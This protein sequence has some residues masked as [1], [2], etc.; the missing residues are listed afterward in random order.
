[1]KSL[2]F[3]VATIAAWPLRVHIEETPLSSQVA[4]VVAQGRSMTLA[5]DE[6]VLA[7]DRCPA[8][9]E[10]AGLVEASSPLVQSTD[11]GEID[12]GQCSLRF[13]LGGAQAG[14]FDG[15]YLW[16]SHDGEGGWDCGGSMDDKLLP[17]ACR[18]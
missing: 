16:F 13:T 12:A 3:G 8:S 2:T 15:E 17:A 7:T 18:G 10:E 5:I 11:L 1:M 6:F 9:L 4:E 14:P